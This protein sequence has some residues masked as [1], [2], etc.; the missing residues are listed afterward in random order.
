[1]KKK[2]NPSYHTDLI[3]R[4][5]DAHHAQAYL[6][7]ALEDNDR[8]VFLL[9]LRDVAEAHGGMTK[10]ARLTH[11]SREHIYRMLSEKGNP[12]LSTL[13]NLLSAVG[14]KLAIEPNEAQKKAA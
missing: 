11:I 3:E 10:L 8:K 6:N 2:A 12:E 9:A 14:L 13:K 1:M 4:L 7:A 5:K